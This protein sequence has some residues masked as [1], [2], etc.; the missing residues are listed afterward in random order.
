MW[1]ALNIS[2]ALRLGRRARVR[3]P[4]TSANLGPGFDALGLALTLHNDVEAEIVERGLELTVAGEG[5]HMLS[6]SADNLVARSAA[7]A[8]GRLGWRPPG[9]R[10][11]C[12]NAV[13][14]GRGLGSSAAAIVAGVS[15]AYALARPG[16]DVDRAWVLD[17]AA[18]IEGHPDN[19]AAC[20]LGAAS[21]GWRDADRR[22][23]GARLEP[24]ADLRAT[25]LVPEQ[26]ASTAI[27]RALLPST[28]PH[29]DAAHAAGRAAL[30]ITAITERLDLLLAATE[31]RL[32]Q[33][34]RATSMPV[35]SALVRRLR[36]AG[37]AAVVSGAGP[38]V[39]VLHSARADGPGD[40][41]LPVGD[42]PLG[43]RTVRLQID[44][45]GLTVAHEG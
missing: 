40:Q 1:G 41:D 12:T 38:T 45:T 43:W 37:M 11:H 35:T 8:F 7:A 17:L 32:H 14:P 28:V 18:E 39:L 5:Q 20:V 9:L 42:L 33:P 3:C 36:A 15:V 26:G 19:V 30:L 31:D 24:H 16:D 27:A 25:A 34:Y 29:A 23:H 22:F 13:P 6:G 21:I 2:R 44:R 4:A 10:L